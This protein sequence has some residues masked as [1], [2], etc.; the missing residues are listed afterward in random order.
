MKVRLGFAVAAHLE[1]DILI[2]DEVLAVGDIGFRVKC[3]NKIADL[4]NNCAVIFV[5]QSMPQITRICS[6]GILMHHGKESLKTNN[7]GQLVESY[8]SRFSSEKESVIG[9]GKATLH[10][11]ALKRYEEIK[12]NIFIFKGNE[13]EINI[14]ISV[15]RQI[16]NFAIHAIVVDIETKPIAI[17]SSLTSNIIF[18]N[19]SDSHSISLVFP[20]IFSDGTYTFYVTAVEILSGN[21]IGDTLISHRGIGKFIIAKKSYPSSIGIEL[22]AVWTV[23]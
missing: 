14:G 21:R 11:F 9:S 23:G 5:S 3:L 7:I 1:P 6:H 15:D 16:E 13:I 4:L 8:F 12:N 22:P 19:N 2:I 20:S 17:A 18:S 10:Q